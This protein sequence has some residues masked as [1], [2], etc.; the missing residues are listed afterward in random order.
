MKPLYQSI[1]GTTLTFHRVSNVKHVNMVGTECAQV[2]SCL[3]TRI[4]NLLSTGSD[5]LALSKNVWFSTVGNIL[6]PYRDLISVHKRVSLQQIS[7]RCSTLVPWIA[8]GWLVGQIWLF[9]VNKQFY[10]FFSPSY[11]DALQIYFSFQKRLSE[12][13][14]VSQVWPWNEKFGKDIASI[15]W[16]WAKLYFWI[17]ILETL[18]RRS[19]SAAPPLVVERAPISLFNHT[20]INSGFSS[21][22]GALACPIQPE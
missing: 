11:F 16:C 13:N 18:F 6:S 3:Y 5:M 21:S 7:L 2:K 4:L 1:C 17:I 20:I 15:I 12:V 8:T 9:P 14:R 10:F 19:S 22:Y